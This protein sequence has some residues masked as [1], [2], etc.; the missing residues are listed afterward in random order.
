M[1]VVILDAVIGQIRGYIVVLASV[2]VRRWAWDRWRPRRVSESQTIRY[3]LDAGYRVAPDG[4]VVREGLMAAAN[5]VWMVVDTRQPVS[6]EMNE[7]LHEAV[8]QW[9]VWDWAC[10]QGLDPNLRAVPHG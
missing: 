7:L 3:M 8:R 4:L 9:A 5:G 1:N 10:K 2:T 6:E